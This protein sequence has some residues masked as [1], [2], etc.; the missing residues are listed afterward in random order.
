MMLG[1]M[2]HRVSPGDTVGVDAQSGTPSGNSPG[3]IVVLFQVFAV[4]HKGC[5]ASTRIESTLSNCWLSPLRHRPDLMKPF[6]S[7]P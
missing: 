4:V 1:Q 5:R 2:L 7:A 6:P 3:G